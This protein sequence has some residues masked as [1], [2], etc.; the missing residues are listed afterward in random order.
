MKEKIF[1]FL[2]SK[3]LFAFMF[4]V[5]IMTICIIVTSFSFE[6]SDDFF[7]SVNICQN[8][9]YYSSSINYILAVIVGSAQYAFGDFNCYV[10]AQILLSCSVFTAITFVFADKF[11]KKIAFGF[12]AIINILFSLYHYQ[13]I[14]G[15]RTSALLLTAGFLLVLN[16]IRNKRYN[17][18]CWIGVAMIAFGS[19]YNYIYYFIAL[20]FAVA[21]FFGDLISKKKFKLPF[22]K[23]FWYFRPFL[24]M[25]LLVT[26]VVF[27]LNRFSYSVNHATEE[28]T[29]Y[30]NYSYLQNS[31][32]NN[33]PY[34]SFEDN[35]EKFADVGIDTE[36]D[37]ELLKSGYYD[38]EKALNLDALQTVYDIQKEDKSNTF[39]TSF[40]DI[41]TDNCHHFTS[42]DCEAFIMLTFTGL[43]ILFVVYQKNRFGFFP[44]FYVAAGLISSTLLR[45]FY[46]GA[47]YFLYG[48]WF[49]ML[50]LLFYSLNFEK[51][52][53]KQIPKLL[54]IKH[55]NFII[56][57]AIIVCLGAG[58]ISVYT[59]HN[60]NDKEEVVPQSLISEIERNPHK[61]YVFDTETVIELY[62]FSENYMHPLWGF[63]DG[64]L[65]NVD[66]FGYFHNTENLVKRNMPTNIYEAVLTNK[67]IYVIDKNDVDIKE[68]Y[69]TNNYT[70][71]GHKV[72]YK[73]LNKINNYCI[74]NVIV[75]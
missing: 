11:N 15:N 74:Y 72:I 21:F 28:A 24:L 66:S 73:L 12:S 70:R 62:R 8:H 44:I 34:P 38:S 53:T 41:F 10:L 2:K 56:T 35:A 51:G 30:Y 37:Y 57:L 22:R 27:G 18:P 50:V 23:F 32:N 7:N 25:F 68:Q 65:D 14:N 52:R 4:N 40:T 9:F 55:G 59:V 36:G 17:L 42:F 71:N 6:S 39:L 67:E 20:G 54:K 45:Y 58:Y 48:I 1:K 49:L 60:S 63:R 64:Y 75:E 26:V 61:Y 16:A 31:I 69:F 46:S 29:R 33:L 5:S 47:N 43:G 3:T 19:F 13:N